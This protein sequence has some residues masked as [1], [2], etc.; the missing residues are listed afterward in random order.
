MLIILSGLSGT[1]KST[2]ARELARQIGAVHLRID[3]IEQTLLQSSAFTGPMDDSGYRVAQA[4]AEDNLRTGHRVIADCVN[5]WPLTRDAW[6]DVA[7]RAGVAWL[8]IEV[9][10]SNL[11]EHRRRVETRAPELPGLPLLAWE[12][13][14]SRDYRPWNRERLVIDTATHT[15]A[16][17]IE[18]LRDRILNRPLRAANLDDAERIGELHL[19]C[20]RA[21]Y[22]NELPP[23][24]FE[25]Q[26]R[27]AWVLRWRDHLAAGAIVL[28]AEHG[29]TL[30]G[31]V[32]YGPARGPS[33]SI[34]VE[35]EIYAIYVAP[36]K[37][38]EG[39]GTRLFDAALE[40]G[41]QHGGEQLVLWVLNTNQAARAF[42]E[43]KGMDVDGAERDELI[44]GETLHEVR[45]RRAL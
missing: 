10:C 35:W 30:L 33:P 4:V 7:R 43:A 28:L 29:D 40:V 22:A 3:S 23:A 27:A 38:R 5:P 45:Y 32:A 37:K 15:V 8:E 21:T 41:R 2:I 18:L 39:I 16:Q 19:A 34:S 12:D 11:T 9:T 26:D 13:V 25:R 17:S 36:D 42:Y 1:G 44:E 24:F 31:F 20:W 14:V 6:V